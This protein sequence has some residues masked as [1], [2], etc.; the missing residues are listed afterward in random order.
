MD[1]VVFVADS[2]QN[3]MAENHESLQNLE[4]NISEYG[5]DL[6]ELPFV[7]QYNKRD[8]PDVLDIPTL[9][10]ELNPRN[11]PHTEATAHNG[12]GVIPTLKLAAKIVI[13]K[14]NAKGAGALNALP[15]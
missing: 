4:E 8:L 2:Q 12:H 3:R 7:I 15:P 1:G 9:Q 10:A 6:K 5:L 11:V 14:F 13:E